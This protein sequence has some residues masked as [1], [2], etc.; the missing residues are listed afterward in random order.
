MNI[1]IASLK[2]VAQAATPGK[3]TDIC[4]EYGYQIVLESEP[5]PGVIVVDD[6]TADDKA[7]V[8]NANPA[9][10]LELIARLGL[11]EN[12][13]ST[14]WIVSLDAWLLCIARIK[15]ADVRRSMTEF[16]L[17]VD[18]AGIDFVARKQML[19]TAMTNLLRFAER[20]ICT[21]EDTHRAGV[22]W[23]VCSACGAKWAD[24]EGGKPEFT[25]PDEIAVARAAIAEPVAAENQGGV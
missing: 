5:K 14:G 2:Q 3:W 11:A 21:H 19:T 24:D 18:Q 9:V 25:W 6:F 22:I 7:Y 13:R 1:D 23:E 4:A 20:N 16:L 12:I 8:L 15:D 10:V 17:K